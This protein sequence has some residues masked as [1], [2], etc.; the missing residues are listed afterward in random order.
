MACNIG[1]VEHLVTQNAFFP[2]LKFSLSS[3]PCQQHLQHVGQR[4]LQDV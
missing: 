2:H 3:Q 1:H 4:A